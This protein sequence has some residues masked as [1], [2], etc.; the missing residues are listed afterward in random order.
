M[1]PFCIDCLIDLGLL[2]DF[3]FFVRIHYFYSRNPV[4]TTPLFTL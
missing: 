3:Q 2:F 4:R 1:H